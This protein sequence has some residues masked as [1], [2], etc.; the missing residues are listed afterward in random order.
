MTRMRVLYREI[1]LTT[2]L[3]PLSYKRRGEEVVGKSTVQ[4]KPSR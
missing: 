1:E 2:Y 3:F 4:R